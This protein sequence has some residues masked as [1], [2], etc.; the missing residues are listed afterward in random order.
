MNRLMEREN[1]MDLFLRTSCCK[2]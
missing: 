1:F 2:C